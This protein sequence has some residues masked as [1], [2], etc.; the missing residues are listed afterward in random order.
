M[1]MVCLTWILV[2]TIRSSW[3][4]RN[5]EHTHLPFLHVVSCFP[6]WVKWNKECSTLPFWVTVPLNLSFLFLFSLILTS[7]CFM[8][9]VEA[10]SVD[11]NSLI[12]AEVQNINAPTKRKIGKEK[13]RFGDAVLLKKEYRDDTCVGTRLQLASR[14]LPACSCC[15]PN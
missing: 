4:R 9:S 12:L 14:P 6:C 7:Y 13:T 10:H 11:I 5:D 2:R 15:W 1:N 3:V 8:C